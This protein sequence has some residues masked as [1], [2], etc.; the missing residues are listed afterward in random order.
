MTLD[1]NSVIAVIVVLPVPLLVA[2]A[3]ARWRRQGQRAV[4]DERRPTSGADLVPAV[5]HQV[6][7]HPAGRQV[8]GAQ[9]LAHAQRLPRGQLC[10]ISQ[11]WE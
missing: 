11:N 7:R 9:D 1:V 3:E 4:A 2:G 5:S 6:R 8:P 10:T